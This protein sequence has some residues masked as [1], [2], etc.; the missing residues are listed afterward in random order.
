MNPHFSYSSL[1]AHDAGVLIPVTQMRK[2]SLRRDEELAQNPSSHHICPNPNPCSLGCTHRFLHVIFLLACQHSVP[3][4][5]HSLGLR[6]KQHVKIMSKVLHFSAQRVT[7]SLTE[8]FTA[9][10]CDPLLDQG[11]KWVSKSIFL[12]CLLNIQQLVRVN[13]RH[14]PPSHKSFQTTQSIYSASGLLIIGRKISPKHC[15][16][17]EEAE[18]LVNIIPPHVHP[19]ERPPPRERRSDTTPTPSLRRGA[20]CGEGT[21]SARLPLRANPRLLPGN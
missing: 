17:S 21:G 14:P 4:E 19:L 13:G 6:D 2:L 9:V 15:S 10:A 1:P 18:Q 12:R 3:T 7:K 8:L 11:L 5:S 16:P 20:H